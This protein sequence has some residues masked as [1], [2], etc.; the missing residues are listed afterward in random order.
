M[1]PEASFNPGDRFG[2]LVYLKKISPDR[3]N[4]QRGLF[5]CDC[6][7]FLE[8]IA[9]R[10]KSGER[11]ECVQCSTKGAAAKKRTHGASATAEYRIWQHMR[12]R[13]ERT[14]NKDYV[15]YGG[16]GI[17]MCERW[18]NSFELFLADMGPRPRGLTIERIDNN[19]PYSPENC[20]WATW[21]EQANNRR[22]GPGLSAK[23]RR[24][25][26][27]RQKELWADPAYRAKRCAA[28]SEG[29][30]RAREAA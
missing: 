21:K 25:S 22:P 24:L 30:A 18:C 4:A 7:G 12:Q 8:V 9:R 11:Q 29:I 15:R 10:V 5:Q 6:G 17:A 23:A 26:I 20:R 1:N 13:C 27:V 2:S 19:G 3:W 28:I 14:A 16:R